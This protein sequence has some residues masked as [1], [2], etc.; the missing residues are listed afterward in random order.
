[1]QQENKKATVRVNVEHHPG[2]KSS[3]EYTLHGDWQDS[4]T[5]LDVAFSSIKKTVNAT[6]L[7]KVTLEYIPACTAEEQA[8]APAE[9]NLEALLKEMQSFKNG[10]AASVDIL[11][12]KMDNLLKEVGENN[13]NVG[14]TF[15]ALART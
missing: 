14:W 12:S 9:T 11:H 10:I 1:M 5:A 13:S 2:A 8:P 3:K 7:C 6:P 15:R 4:E